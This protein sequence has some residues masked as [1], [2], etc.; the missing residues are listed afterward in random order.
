MGRTGETQGEPVDRAITGPESSEVDLREDGD[1]RGENAGEERHCG[2]VDWV[3]GWAGGVDP[4]RDRK[5]V[6]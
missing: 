2:W 5:S 1:A 4:M 3:A 6:V